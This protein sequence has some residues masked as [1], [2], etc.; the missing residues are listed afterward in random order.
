M[1]QENNKKHKKKK[2]KKEKNKKK[3]GKQ[4]DV[5]DVEVAHRMTTRYHAHITTG[6]DKCTDEECPPF[7]LPFGNEQGWAPF[8]NAAEE[9]S[10]ADLDEGCGAR[11][12]VLQKEAG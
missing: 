10:K 2:E 7:R 3:K 9:G 11:S 8:H 1:L 6:S 5:M 12:G 4:L